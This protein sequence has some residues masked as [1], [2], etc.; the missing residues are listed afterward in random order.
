[1]CQALFLGTWNTVVNEMAQNIYLLGHCD[2][3]WKDRK[4]M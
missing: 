1:M 3:V 4:E 2:L